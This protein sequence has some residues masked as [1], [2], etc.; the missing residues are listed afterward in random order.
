MRVIDISQEVFSCRVYPGDPA[1]EVERIMDMNRGDTYNLSRFS[2]C[3]HNGTH[4]D[5]PA[6]FMKEGKTVDEIPLEY[7]TGDCLVLRHTGNVSADD[8]GEMLKKAAGTERILIAGDAVVTADAAR[9]FA[10]AGV[11]L[12]G[13][14]SQSV[15]PEDAPMEVH[16]ILLSAQVVLLEGIVLK[17]VAEGRYF[18][19]AA[20][21]NLAGCEGAPCRAYLIEQ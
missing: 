17:D 15:G 13:N 12:L 2:M 9:V 21:L 14:E 6:H 19:S 20:P 5:A 16:R 4:V 7:F 3:V 18:L 1:P 11:K 8:A 10:A